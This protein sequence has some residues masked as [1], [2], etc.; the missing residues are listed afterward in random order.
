[1]GFFC[2]T[3]TSTIYKVKNIF[4]YFAKNGGFGTVLVTY[5]V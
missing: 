5:I 1:M 2:A 3:V 4:I